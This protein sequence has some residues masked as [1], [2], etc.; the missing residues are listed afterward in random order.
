MKET[1]AVAPAENRWG[2]FLSG[3]GEWVNVGD[4][5]NARGY[6]LTSG[7]F[8]L[9]ID[10]KVTSNFAIG[11]MAGYTGTSADLVDRG[12]VY[13]NGGKIGIYATT[14]AGRLVCRCGDH[15]RLQQ[16]RTPA[17]ARCKAKPAATP[18]AASSTPSSALATTS[19]KATSPSAPRPPST[20]LTSAPTPSPSTAP[21]HRWTSTAAKAN[22]CAPRWA[23]RPATTG[24]SAA[25]SS[26]PRFAPPAARVRRRGLCP[27]L[28]F[29][30]RRR[31][32]LPRQRTEARSRQ[33]AA[34]RRLRDPVQRTL[35]DLL[36]L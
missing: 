34:G 3:T 16:L 21:W 11:L 31:Q 22:R 33:P 29:R 9:G 12:R 13:V 25:S 1:K 19:R 18:T 8:T 35:L 32:L 26:S 6:D 36:L 23:S 7:G 10:Y 24:R 5:D 4:T 2:A 14:F 27:R 28:Q 15:W 30:Q 20:T 17:A